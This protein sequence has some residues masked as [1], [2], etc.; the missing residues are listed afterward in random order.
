MALF[1]KQPQPSDNLPYTIGSR[2]TLLVL[3]LGNPG[4]QYA[5]TR[6][7]AGFMAADQAAEKLGASAWIRK[8]NWQV[9]IAEASISGARLI[10]AKPQAFMNQSGSAAAALQR[11]YKISNH[12]TLV[13]YDELAIPFGQ[14][15]SRR[16]G[17]DA[18]HKG[19]KSL[20]QHLGE[21]FYRLRVGIGGPALKEPSADY[22]LAKFTSSEQ[23]QLPLVIR[24]TVAMVGE[25]VING[26]LPA[27][28][29]KVI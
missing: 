20:I 15:R 14:I 12:E 25:F 6:H 26:Q 21:D 11:F 2:K 4:K 24:E 8:R 16:G 10:L 19:V 1:Q 18:G 13:I 23:T 29:R 7:N 17:S 3:G 27:E 22:V 28:T 9:D 5:A